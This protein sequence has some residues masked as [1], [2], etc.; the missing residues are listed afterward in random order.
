MKVKRVVLVLAVLAMVVGNS[1]AQTAV[2]IGVNYWRADV[3][4]ETGGGGVFSEDMTGEDG[5]ELSMDP[6]NMIGP[7]VSLSLGKIV[8]GGSMSSGE[9]NLDMGELQDLYR[10]LFEFDI[11]YDIKLKR[12]DLNFS[13]GYK[14][15][16]YITAFGAYKDE[17]MT[18]AGDVSV[19]YTDWYG[20][21]QSESESVDEEIARESF[22][23]GGLSMAFPFSGSPL[24]AFGSAAYLAANGDEMGD[25]TTVTFGLG[26]ATRANITVMVGYR[27]DSMGDDQDNKEKIKGIMAT[28]AYTIR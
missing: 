16:K 4:L 23:G 1:F 10:N 6:G 28:A 18:L 12:K 2:S 3:D 8:I 9:F 26:L 24:F 19:S 21:T 15:S 22:V 13:V 5:I 7:Y 20:D 27:V 11:E 14:L 25:I 17:T